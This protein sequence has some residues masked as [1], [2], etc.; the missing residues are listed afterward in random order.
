MNKL[1][2]FFATSLACCIANTL[3][4]A[5]NAFCVEVTH[6]GINLVR[7]E[8]TPEGLFQLGKGGPSKLGISYSHYK[9]DAKSGEILVLKDTRLKSSPLDT[10]VEVASYTGALSGLL[11]ALEAAGAPVGR[12]RVLAVYGGRVQEPGGDNIEVSIKGFRGTIRELLT[13][14]PSKLPIAAPDGFG[15]FVW[16]AIVDKDGKKAAIYYSHFE[17]EKLSDK[18]MSAETPSIRIISSPKK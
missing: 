11:N 7:E 16:Q 15:T 9:I 1:L 4:A 12:P 18:K 13:I 14:A 5:P 8:L 2:C 6:E 10:E 3:A 17:G